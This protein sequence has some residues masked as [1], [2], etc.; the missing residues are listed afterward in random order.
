[1]FQ[2]ATAPT[3]PATQA[4]VYAHLSYATLVRELQSLAS[5]FPHLASAWTTQQRFGLPSAGR[6]D[7][8]PCEVWVLE[9]THRASLTRHPERPDVLVS[10]ALHGD[11][12]V[13]PLATLEL[14]RWLLRISFK[15]R[16]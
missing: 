12:R 7:G 14:A 9:V 2:R 1:M 6:C 13:G 3:Q 4:A 15:A 16:F 10:G 8:A 5:E 11:E